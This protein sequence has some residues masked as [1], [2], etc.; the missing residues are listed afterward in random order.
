MNRRPSAGPTRKLLLKTPFLLLRSLVFF[1]A[2]AAFGA[3]SLTQTDV[4]V[5]GKDGYNTFLIPAIET[6]PD[7]SLIAFAE[8]RKY[9]A[10][11]PGFGS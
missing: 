2:T 9:T 8:A 10:E 3:P 11:D 7:G 4:F 6:A 5:S 1:S